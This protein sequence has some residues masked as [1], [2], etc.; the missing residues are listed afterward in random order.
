MS[1]G[2]QASGDK[3]QERIRERNNSSE[4]DSSES[5]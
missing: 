2:I 5:N 3:I 4:N 1:Q